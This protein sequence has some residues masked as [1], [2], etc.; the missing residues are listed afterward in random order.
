M[1]E[2]S[3][4]NVSP[5]CILGLDV[6]DKRVGVAFSH[7]DSGVATPY[8]TL[9]RAG[10]NAEQ[11]IINLVKE[12]GVDLVLIGLPLGENGEV[13]EQCRKIGKFSKR[14]RKRISVK[15]VY[16]DEYA[17]S[18]EAAELLA[19]GRSTKMIKKLGKGAIDALSAMLIVSSYLNNGQYIDFDSIDL[20]NIG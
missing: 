19:K 4:N 14:L 15:I 16:I 5:N 12:L 3:I 11:D 2:N 6:G 18:I 17:T 1:F 7:R 9:D 10:G 20:S 13:G 8:A